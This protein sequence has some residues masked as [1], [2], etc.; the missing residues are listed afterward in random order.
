MKKYAGRISDNFFVQDTNHHE[1]WIYSRVLFLFNNTRR[2]SNISRSGL[3]SLSVLYGIRTSVISIILTA[4][5]FF[6]AVKTNISRSY[7]SL[8]YDCVEKKL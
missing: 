5:C 1:K 4:M 3:H 6:L 2:I 8:K 7:V